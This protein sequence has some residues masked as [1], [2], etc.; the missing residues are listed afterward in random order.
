MHYSTFTLISGDS[1]AALN[2]G[3]YRLQIGYSCPV[4]ALLLKKEVISQLQTLN[5][6]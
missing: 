3:H 2:T 4:T 5:F 1:L 6:I